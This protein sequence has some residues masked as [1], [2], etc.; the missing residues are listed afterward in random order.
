MIMVLSPCKYAVW[1]VVRKRLRAHLLSRLG[2]VQPAPDGLVHEGTLRQL[3]YAGLAR[4][5]RGD[6][7]ALALDPQAVVPGL[8]DQAMQQLWDTK[9]VA[10]GPLP[11]VGGGTGAV[12]PAAAPVRPGQ[13]RNAV[14][15]RWLVQHKAALKD[16]AIVAG[17]DWRSLG[18]RRFRSV[19]ES[20]AEYLALLARVRAQRAGGAPSR[21]IGAN[22]RWNS[23][24]SEQGDA[25]HLVVVPQLMMV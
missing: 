12:E 2:G 24:P 19:S 8:S 13:D 15:N 18:C 7:A 23:R 16:D 1:L 25:D 10:E 17:C 11:E 22:G 21:L 4:L 14:K 6:I 9:G 5:S 3:A 20:S